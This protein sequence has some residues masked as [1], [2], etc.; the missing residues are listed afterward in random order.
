MMALIP[1]I[2]LLVQE[3]ITFL[4]KMNKFKKHPTL[5]LQENGGLW[6]TWPC[7][8]PDLLREKG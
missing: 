4:K 7:K 6:L 2:V 8:G 1:Q 3:V 5:T